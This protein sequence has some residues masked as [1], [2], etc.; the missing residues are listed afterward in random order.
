MY[1]ISV[2][3]V[4]CICITGVLAVLEVSNTIFI[5]YN[6]VLQLYNTGY[7]YISVLISSEQSVV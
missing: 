5:T 1:M 2:I 3:I 6:T 7:Q 4:C